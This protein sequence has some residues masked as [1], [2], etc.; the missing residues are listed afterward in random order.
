VSEY[1]GYAQLDWKPSPAWRAVL[2]SR[3]T[4]NELFGENI[5]S[6]GSLVYTIN[7]K[8]AIKFI[9]GQSF[10]APSLFE[11]YFITPS[12]TIFGNENLQPETADTFELGY[13]H[14]RGYL[15]TMSTSIQMVTPSMPKD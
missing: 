6:R 14:A 13:Q 12:Q 2:G 1:S 10:R 7:E 3:F 4:Q 8:N 15:S 9:A 5:S 11:L